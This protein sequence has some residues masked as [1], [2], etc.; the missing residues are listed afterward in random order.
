MWLLVKPFKFVA[1][2]SMMSNFPQKCTNERK[3][4]SDTH[5]KNKKREEKLTASDARYKFIPFM[6]LAYL[7]QADHG[8][9]II[10]CLSF[11]YSFLFFLFRLLPP[12]LNQALISYQFS[13]IDFKYITKGRKHSTKK[14]RARHDNNDLVS[15]ASGE[16]FWNKKKKYISQQLLSA[17]SSILSEV[18]EIS[19]SITKSVFTSR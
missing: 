4:H 16:Y 7:C 9:C 17:A 2:L 1:F 8:K 11:R 10:C 18:N 15:T 6:M 12:V 3:T 13:W 14:T 5:D 19:V